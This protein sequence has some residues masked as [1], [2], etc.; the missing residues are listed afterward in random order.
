MKTYY[1]L[2]CHGLL[3]Q[4]LKI[5][6]SENVNEYENATKKNGVGL[7]NVAQICPFKSK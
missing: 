1:T 7:Q 3:E 2:F 5:N 4:F 6:R